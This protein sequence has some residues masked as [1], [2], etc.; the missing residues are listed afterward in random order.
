MNIRFV[1]MLAFAAGMF[2]QAPGGPAAPPPKT[3]AVQAYLGLTDA[4]IQALQQL[5]QTEMQQV[6]PLRD[7]IAQKQKAIYDQLEAGSTD[8]PAL[9]RLLVDIQSV[10]KQI[11]QVEGNF[12]TQAINMLN[13]AEK[14]KLK[15]LDDATKGGTVPQAIA[16]QLLTRPEGANGPGGPGRPGPRGL[17]GPPPGP[18]GPAN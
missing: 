7:Q 14:T 11:T 10:R 2:A 16:L 1:F 4:Q 5:R 13:A 8:A 18:P 12:Q 3:D 17:D 9:G 6:R 15:A